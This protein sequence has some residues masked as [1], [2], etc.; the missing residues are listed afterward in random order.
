MSL[1]TVEAKTGMSA[2]W[3]KMLMSTYFTDGLE[4]A[5]ALK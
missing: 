4:A 1:D 5:Y 3:L 2:I